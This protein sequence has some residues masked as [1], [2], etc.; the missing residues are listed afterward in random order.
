[1]IRDALNP[2]NLDSLKQAVDRKMSLCIMAQ[3]AGGFLG[4]M[5][6]SWVAQ[7]FGRRPGFLISFILCLI[8]IPVT[9]YFTDSFVRAIIFFPLMGFSLLMIFGGYAVYFPEIFPTRL[10]ATGVGVSYNVARF[11]A[12]GAPF[13]FG[14][15]K[16]ITGS[17]PPPWF[18][19]PSSSWRC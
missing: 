14:R 9:F 18:S 3:N 7:R 1:L 17:K 16:G 15:S 13:V 12:A 8:M 5:A 10:R 2:D 11:L 6:Y 4:V 19:P